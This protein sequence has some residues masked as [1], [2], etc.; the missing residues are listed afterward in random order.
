MSGLDSRL[1]AA[2]ADA[3][4]GQQNFKIFRI[5][6]YYR[7]LLSVILGLSYQFRSPSSPLGSIAPELFVKVLVFYGL[8]SLLAV[9]SAPLQASSSAQTRGIFYF[10]TLILDI[11]LLTLLSYA[12]SGVSSGLAHL[13]IIPVATGSIVFGTRLGIFLASVGSIAAIY[14][15]SYLNFVSPNMESYYVQ[16][17][18]LGMTLFSI[19]LS[20]QYLGFRIRQKEQV[21]RKQAASIQS[22]QQI[23]QQVI[24]RM[25]TGIVVVSRS[26]YIINSNDSARK[27][28]LNPADSEHDAAAMT[29]LPPPL[30]EQLDA[31]LADPGQALPTFQMHA[32]APELLASFTTLEDSSDAANI[33][34][35]L[36]DYS[37]LSSRAQHLKLMSLGRLTA[38]IAHE[39]RNPLGAISH[40]CQ[41]LAESSGI[42]PQDRRLLDII[43]T[44]SGRVNTI[45]ENILA[46]SRPRQQAAELI[47][48]PHWLEQFTASFCNS[49]SEAVD[50]VLHCEDQ[51]LTLYFNPNQLER[52]LTNLCENAVRYSSQHA[53]RPHV[54]IHAS[55]PDPALGPLVDVVD[56]GPGVPEA[57]LDQIFE[58]FFTTDNQGTG[59]GLFMCR[60]ICEANLARIH[61]CRNHDGQ[62]CFRIQ[63]AHPE[64]RIH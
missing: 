46:H 64:G 44:H 61:H 19:S 20:L 25:H 7:L 48:L 21:N 23:N 39:I 29:Q 13:L 17:G 11:L 40:A 58:P 18:L 59:L 22:L 12:C 53:G 41:L 3:E 10:G 38:S 5:Y 56:L 47:D 42:Q 43:N 4:T 15:E 31:W 36:E 51:P 32:G 60:E 63:F 24:E 2:S 54:G 16:A 57:E 6:Q 49:Y 26:G 30:Q 8:T 9:L 37:Q 55:R 50:C 28:S 62:S 1:L 34:I 27:L 14:S 33:L 35:F 52:L 45:I